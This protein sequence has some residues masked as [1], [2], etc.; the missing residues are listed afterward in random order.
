MRL[1]ANIKSCPCPPERSVSLSSMSP[2]GPISAL[3]ALAFWRPVM[4]MTV[5][6]A[7]SIVVAESVTEMVLLAQGKG[8]L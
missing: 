4:V 2:A 1:G 8:L 6:L 7:W 3:G 5:V